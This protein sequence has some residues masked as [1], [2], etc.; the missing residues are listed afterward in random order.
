M[1]RA[2]AGFDYIVIGAGSSGC[3]I[4]NRLSADPSVRVA[5]IEAGPSDRRFPVNLK[6][7]LPIG[8][9]VLLPHARYNWQHVFTGGDGVN[10]RVIGCP[11]GKLFGGCSSVNGSVYIRGHRSD[12]DD[13]AALGNEG[14]DYASV[15]E[16]YKRHENRRAGASEHHGVGGELDVQWPASLNPLSRAFVE[17]A[18]EAGHRRNDDFNGDVQDGYGAYEL[19]Q[20][21]GTRLSNSRAF[22]HPVLSRPNLHVFAE[23]LV[24]RID[25]SGGRATG[26]TIVRDGQRQRLTAASEVIL[27][28]GAV[29]SPQLLMLSGI[30]PEAALRRHGIE[31][32]VAL[33]GV[34]QNL[35]DH[36]TVFV[37]TRNPGAESYALSLR[38]LPR[39]AASPLRYLFGRR[40]M[41]ASN[42]AEAGGFLRTLPGL[43]RPDVQ[44]TF[45]VGLKGTARTIPREHGFLLLVQLLR[46]VSRGHLELASADLQDRPVMHPRFLDDPADVATLVRGLREARRIFAASALARYAQGELE[47]GRDVQ[48]DAQLEAAI[49]AQVTTAYHPVGTCKMG[50]ASDAFAVVDA[51]LRVHGIEGLRVADASIM[52]NIVGGNTSGPA[53]MIGERAADFILGRPPARTAAAP[54]TEPALA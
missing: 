14:W 44:M 34:G 54:H 20:R 45:L 16:A 28:G 13:W 3:V 35:Q 8:N 53:T 32:S 22:L 42:A 49:R 52:P 19:N 30:G 11:R 9:I 10:R 7:R 27:S 1:P 47:P 21:D 37:S 31:V 36:P 15:L 17:A 39:I 24:E 6:T 26:V 12:Y 48:T 41:L 33:P 25:L 38:S 43:T 29:N 18:V 46:P 4:A 5:L 23:T 50:P 2:S 51:Q 40:G